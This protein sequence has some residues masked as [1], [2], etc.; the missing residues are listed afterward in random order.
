MPD[1]ADPSIT[2][3]TLR[4]LDAELGAV[5]QRTVDRLTEV[6]HEMQTEILKGLDAVATTTFARLERLETTLGDVNRRLADLEE[7]VLNLELM[8]KRPN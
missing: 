6:L 1:N 3:A 5:G 8:R 4:D 7:R 2:P